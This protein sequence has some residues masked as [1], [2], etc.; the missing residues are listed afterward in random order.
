LL[1]LEP[2]EERWMAV[3]EVIRGRFT[4]GWW[5][6]VR[7]ETKLRILKKQRSPVNTHV[8]EA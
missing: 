2:W 3:G 6:M 1:R 4:R 5:V 7:M 8:M